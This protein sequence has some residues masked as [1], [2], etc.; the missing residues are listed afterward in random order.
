MTSQPS[1][2]DEVAIWQLLC[3]YCHLVDRGEM[4]DVINLFH[5]EATLIFPPSPPAKGHKAILEAYTIWRRTA[6]EPTV[7]LRHQLSTPFITVK[8]SRA[9]AVSY[10]T[11]DF[12]LR[13]KGRVEALVGRYQ[14]ELLQQD[15]HWLLWRREILIDARLDLGEP[16]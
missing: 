13:K 15:D 12:L 5:P 14:D 2:P 4:T 3:R 7:W 9:T 10:L 8:G 16:L 6:R 1:I 11:A